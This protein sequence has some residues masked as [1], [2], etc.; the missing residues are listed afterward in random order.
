[1]EATNILL[2]IYLIS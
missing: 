1:L 2:A